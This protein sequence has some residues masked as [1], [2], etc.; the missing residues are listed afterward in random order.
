MDC[1]ADDLAPFVG[2]LASLARTRPSMA[3]G[4]DPPCLRAAGNAVA[5]LGALAAR[6][7]A[8]A[9]RDHRHQRSHGRRI[10]RRTRRLGRAATGKPIH[11]RA[12]ARYPMVGESTVPG[13]RAARWLIRGAMVGSAKGRF[14][15]DDVPARVAP[16]RPTRAPDTDGTFASCRANAPPA[17]FA[18]E[19]RCATAR[20]ETRPR[21]RPASRNPSVRS[22][23][24]FAGMFGSFPTAET[25]AAA[26]ETTAR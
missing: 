16:A 8:L 20:S 26:V 19:A 21:G 25:S 14:S 17:S 22:L 11:L 15:L 2:S 7:S 23:S 5:T 24:A 9:V 10:R 3:A 4:R 12:N 18:G 6:R 1:R 13:V